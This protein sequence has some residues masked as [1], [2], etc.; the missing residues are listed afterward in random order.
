MNSKSHRTGRFRIERR[1]RCV[2][3][4]VGERDLGLV[5]R[6]LTF[7]RDSKA[8]L[9]ARSGKVVNANELACRLF[10][11]PLQDIVGLPVSN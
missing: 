5:W 3:P 2:Q 6:G 4:P 7:G 9:L 10:D 1:Q 8:L 11:R